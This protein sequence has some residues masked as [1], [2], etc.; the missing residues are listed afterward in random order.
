L[1]SHPYVGEY[2]QIPA[3]GEQ[4]DW[5]QK[6]WVAVH[7][8]SAF[9]WQKV[10][11]PHIPQKTC[12]GHDVASAGWDSMIPAIPL[13]ETTNAPNLIFSFVFMINS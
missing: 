10:N 7:P 12:V 3:I 13:T 9:S 11:V 5:V 1:G 6:A 4:R 2:S 8:G